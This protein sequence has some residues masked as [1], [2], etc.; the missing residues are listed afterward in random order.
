MRTKQYHQLWMGLL[1]VASLLLVLA[2]LSLNRQAEQVFAQAADEEPNPAITMYAE[3]MGISY[4]EAERRLQLQDKMGPVQQKVI[5]GEPTYAG[6]WMLHQPE[7]G[8]VVAFAAPDGEAIMQKY[9][10]GIAWADLVQVIELPYTDDE[11]LAILTQVNQAAIATGIPFESGAT[12]QRSKVTLWTLQPDELRTQLAANAAI[13]DYLDDIEYIYQAG[14]SMPATDE[15]ALPF[16]LYL[17][18]VQR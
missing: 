15:E 6:S 14:I 18:T 13:V 1:A 16:K 7:F 10:E 3:A 2:T 11:L 5:Q 4:A 12:Y 9:L 17:P 8:L